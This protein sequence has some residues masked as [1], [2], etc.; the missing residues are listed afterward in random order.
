LPNPSRKP[1]QRARLQGS[2]QFRKRRTWVAEMFEQRVGE[3][4]IKRLVR[5]RELINARLSELN[6]EAFVFSLLARVPELRI[7]EINSD[8]LSWSHLPS[9]FSVI[10]PGPQPA[11]SRR[12]PGL[13]FG[14]KNPA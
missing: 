1:I 8:L 10:V 12:Q 6:V 5:E 2:A 11:S 9:Q 3:H 7:L 4:C 13:N 14:R